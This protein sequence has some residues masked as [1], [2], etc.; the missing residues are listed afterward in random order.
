MAR[1][2]SGVFSLISGNPVI[3]GSTVSSTWANNT[4]SDIANALTTSIATDGQAVVT[5][6]IPMNSKKLT[7]LASATTAGDALA[8]GQTAMGAYNGSTGT[9]SGLI[10]GSVGATLGNTAVAGGTVLDWYEENTLSLN[11]A[12]GSGAVVSATAVGGFTRIGNRV[13]FDL[14]LNGS[15]FGTAAGQI[16]IT[17]LPYAAA[18]D[19]II[20]IAYGEGSTSSVNCWGFIGS[21]TTTM[22]FIKNNGAIFQISDAVVSFLAN[23]N[24]SYRV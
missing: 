3:T 20:P 10:A 5:A 7:G 15:N 6:N 4:L 18:A 17:G 8:Y 22:F 12:G 16:R 21:G 24:G 11:M 23:V 9:F 19:T 14:L 1:N 13:A 2:G